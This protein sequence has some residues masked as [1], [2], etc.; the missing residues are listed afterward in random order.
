[1]RSE[2]EVQRRFAALKVRY[3]KRTL[4]KKMRRRPSNCHFNREHTIKKDGEEITVRLC[5][6]GVERPEWEVDICDT[7]EQ[8]MSCPA[9][10]FKQDREAV[11]E[12]FEETFSQPEYLRDNHKDLFALS[13]VLEETEV[14]Y[15][16]FQRLELFVERVRSRVV[17]LWLRATRRRKMLPRVDNDIQEDE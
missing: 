9:F 7:A 1:M 13:W 10:L 6:L 14:P 11:E 12:E 8:A 17:D 2:D 4:R 3:L 5:V 15:S 16:L